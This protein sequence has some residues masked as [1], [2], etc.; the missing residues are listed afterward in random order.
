MAIISLETADM[1]CLIPTESKV[2]TV[3]WNDLSRRSSSFSNK[4]KRIDYVLKLEECFR[5]ICLYA[6]I[7][8]CL[9]KPE[10]F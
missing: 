3:T 1:N 10:S 5:S 6:H 4:L 8:R 9:M 7:S 2:F